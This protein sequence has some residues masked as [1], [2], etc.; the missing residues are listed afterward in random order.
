MFGIFKKRPQILD[1][2]IVAMSDSDMYGIENVNDEIFSTKQ[3]GDGVAFSFPKRK[4]TLCA[5][6]NGTLC[7]LFS[8]GHAFGIKTNNGTELLIHIGIDTVL[9]N[10]KG[11]LLLDKK[12]GDTVKAGDPIVEV[13]Y[14]LLSKRY[15]MSTMMIVTKSNDEISFAKYGKYK[16]YQSIL[17]K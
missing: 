6:A 15:D 13:D 9:S 1:D 3:L 7:M 5:P 14:E 16:K 17:N 11:F 8:T 4:V 10:G 12:Q 2:D